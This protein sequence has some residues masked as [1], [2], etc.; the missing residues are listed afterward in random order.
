MVGFFKFLKRDKK[1]EMEELDLPPEPPTLDGI[2]GNLPEFP[3]F[4]DFQEKISAPKGSMPNFDLP[5]MGPTEAQEPQFSRDGFPSFPELEKELPAMPENEP[6]AQDIVP[7]AA[8]AAKETAQETKPRVSADAHPKIERRLFTHE[9]HPL[10]ERPSGKM[11]YIRVDRFKSTLG[12]I[13]TVRNDLKKSE[14]IAAKLENINNTKGRSSERAKMQL[15]DLQK[16][17][18]FIDKTLFKGE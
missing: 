12:S 7:E 8:P 18:I 6:L 2:E 3:E 11:V 4:S 5:E 10:R 1:R 15:E 17:L 16:K 14:D 9:R 13:N